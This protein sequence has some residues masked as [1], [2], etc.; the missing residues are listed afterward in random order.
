MLPL[1]TET[2]NTIDKG[3]AIALSEADRAYGICILGESMHAQTK[4][5]TMV[6]LNQEHS[7]CC[8]KSVRPQP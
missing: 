6:S 2:N 5:A 1:G 8:S 7:R 3:T 4:S